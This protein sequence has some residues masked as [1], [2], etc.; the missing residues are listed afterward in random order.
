MT[1]PRHVRV[2]LAKRRGTA[3]TR[4]LALRMNAPDRA[5]GD[6]LV[7]RL[8]RGP[9]VEWPPDPEKLERARAMVREPD[10]FASASRPPRNR[11]P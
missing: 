11:E 6:A 7:K 2:K 9:A 4:E 3:A 1:M 10:L 5:A 8:K